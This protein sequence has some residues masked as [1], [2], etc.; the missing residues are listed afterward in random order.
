MDT[1]TIS[2]ATA[3]ILFAALEVL[4]E[5]GDVLLDQVL[6]AALKALASRINNADEVKQDIL[7]IAAELESFSDTSN[8]DPLLN[9]SP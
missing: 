6:A 3:A 4:P 5:D 8:P 9:P 2:P 1:D 7:D